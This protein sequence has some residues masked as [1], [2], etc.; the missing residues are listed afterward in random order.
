MT[1]LHHLGFEEYKTGKTSGSRTLFLNQD[2]ITIRTHKPHPANIV[3]VYVIDE[4]S[5]LLERNGLI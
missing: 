1:L 4:I 2:G 3:K 5:D